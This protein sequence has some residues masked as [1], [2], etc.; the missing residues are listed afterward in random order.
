M[1]V[2]SIGEYL[3]PYDDCDTFLSTDA[4]LTWSMVHKDAAKYEFGDQGSIIVIVNDEEATD[5][6]R[7]S[8]NDGKT[9]E[10]VDLGVSLRAR[11]ITT[12]PDSTS[13]KF[14]LVGTTSR[15]DSSGGRHAVVF[16]DF[17]TVGKRKC[18]E[19]DFEKWYARTAKD[20]ECLMGHKVFQLWFSFRVTEG[21]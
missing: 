9:W 14:I 20:K 19:K 12:I 13:Q 11:L 15:K 21:N 2:G 6:V 10:K 1:G 3:R 5:K 8:Y 18:E 16:I 17:A 7:Y 4:G